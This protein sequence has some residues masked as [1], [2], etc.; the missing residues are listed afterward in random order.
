MNEKTKALVGTGIL[1]AIVI[2]LQAMTASIRLGPFSVT[3]VL[4]PIVVGSALY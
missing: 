2:V 1:T 4:I 3:F